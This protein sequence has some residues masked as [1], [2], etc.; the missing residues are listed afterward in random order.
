MVVISELVTNAIVHGAAPILVIVDIDDRM[1]VNVAVTD[2]AA[3]VP[4]AD[5]P[6]AGQVGGWG[7]ELVEQV[8]LSWGVLPQP[9]EE[10]GKIVW[11]HL[12]L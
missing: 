12:E 11:A 7:M 1:E 6:V 10:T 3:D 2:A 5:S 4:V 8:S 9:D